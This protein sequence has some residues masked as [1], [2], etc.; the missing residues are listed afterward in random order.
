MQ[1]LGHVQVKQAR[2]DGQD[3][4]FFGIGLSELT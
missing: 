4:K 1:D 2:A 3:G